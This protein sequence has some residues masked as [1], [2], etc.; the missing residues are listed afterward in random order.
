MESLKLKVVTSALGASSAMTGF[1]SLSSCTG[2]CG[3]CLGCAGAGLGLAV[4]FLFNRKKAK[5]GGDDAVA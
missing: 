3:A 1:L 5:T 4:V 2:A